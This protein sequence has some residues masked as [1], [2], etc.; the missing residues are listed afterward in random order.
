MVTYLV[1]DRVLL[2]S[3]GL[4]LL[5]VV[6][7]MKPVG[8]GLPAPTVSLSANPSSITVIAGSFASAMITV[9]IQPTDVTISNAVVTCTGIP[10]ATC[11]T[12]PNPLPSP[13]SNGQQFTLTVSVPASTAPGTYQG[14]VQFSYQETPAGM[15]Q[16]VFVAISP[17]QFGSSGGIGPSGISIS[18]DPVISVTI[19][20]IVQPATFPAVHQTPVG[21]VMLPSLGLTALLP[22]VLVLSSLGAVSVE[23]FRVKRHAKRR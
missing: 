1:R 7:V 13:M 22:W 11:S 10:G 17:I 6:G 18:Q 20:V 9:T 4:I 3:L 14:S 21:G 5:F 19:T 2:F 8:A 15:I 23:A 16:P 12:N